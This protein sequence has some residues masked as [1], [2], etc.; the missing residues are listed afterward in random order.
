MTAEVP[1]PKGLKRPPNSVKGPSTPR[2]ASTIPWKHS[3]EETADSMCAHY[4][5]AGEIRRGICLL[6]AGQFDQASIAFQRAI[7]AGCAREE[8]SAYLA[9]CL[10][11][12]GK[13]DEAARLFR[14]GPDE[15]APHRAVIRSALALAAADQA[16]RAIDTLRQGLA[17][18]PECAELH[19][20][21]GLLLATNGAYEEAELRF[22]QAASLDRDHVDALV[23]LGLCCGV[24]HAPAEAL[25]HL[26]RAQSRRPD[27]ARI[28]LLL[29]QA[30]RTARQL[31][32]PVRVRA[33]M[34]EPSTGRDAKCIQELAEIIEKDSDLIEA[35][36]AAPDRRLT[37]ALAGALEI[38]IKRH[39]D[40]AEFYLQHAQAVERLGKTE[41]AVI[42][43]E[44][45]VALD[46][47]LARAMVE[48][49]RLYQMVNRPRDAIAQLEQATR[50]GARYADVYL[51][52]GNLYRELRQHSRA[53]RMYEEALTINEG[54]E[55][56]RSALASLG[57]ESAD[58]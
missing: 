54:Y 57:R 20:Q 38:L 5:A 24:R 39:P 34:P 2:S 6:N 28:G 12:Q 17:T 22:E 53:R 37:T 15:Q 42:E 40:K 3:T 43:A 8:L 11:S 52:L 4:R 58:A 14:D 13:H 41:L 10:I 51:R 31:G 50:S 44:R 29:A 23:N 32:Q 47:T 19:F 26:Q 9:A 7:D 55:A 27:D 36:L 16:D 35:L 30:A 18:F 49:G 33:V 46:P 1:E 48:L 56:A 25:N 45:A 21:L